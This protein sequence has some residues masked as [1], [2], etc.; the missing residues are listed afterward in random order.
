M[1]NKLGDHWTYIYDAANRLVREV[2]PQV[3]Q[4]RVQGEVW[5]QDFSENTDGLT[6]TALTETGGTVLDTTE[7][8]SIG[9]PNVSIR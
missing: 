3:K 9:N 5:T 2:S 6:G 1:T 4:T 7:G 8:T